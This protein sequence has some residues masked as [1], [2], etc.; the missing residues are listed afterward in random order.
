MTD[1]PLE[2]I[3]RKA[4]LPPRLLGGPAA[5]E[6]GRGEHEI[7]RP[8]ADALAALGRSGE[9][10]AYTGKGLESLAARLA[11]DHGV[12]HTHLCSSGTAAV[13]LALRGLGIGP[14][15]EVILSAYDFRGNFSNIC[16]TGATP[17]LVDIRPDNGQLDVQQVPSA[18]TPATKAILASHLHGGRA[19][20]EALRKISDEQS[21][22][23]VE[24][25][26]QAP[27]AIVDGR[28]AGSWGD[29]SV[30]SFGGSKLLS[31]GRGGAVL[32]SRDDI[33]Q[34]IR[35]YTQRGND[36]YPLSEIQAA[37]LLPQWERLGEWN[38]RR[39]S[40]AAKLC[41]W[42]KAL[43]VASLVPWIGECEGTAL[44]KLGFWHEPSRGAGGESLTRDQFAAAAQAEG[45]PLA[46]GFRALHASHAR[47][48]FRAVGELPHTTRADTT[49]LT[50]HHTA[51]EGNE[52]SLHELA[53]GL[54]KVHRHASEL[55]A[56]PS[57][58][59]LRLS[60]E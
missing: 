29:V 26:C 13:E 33:L 37:I 1:P 55:A 49:V 48:R 8:V 53:A 23:L 52:Q 38:R 43:G 3:E 18:I 51:M 50:L 36:A 9:W 4:S 24:D 47:R 44:Y 30:L 10:R 27:G 41:G 28:I 60:F 15:D 42:L 5:C 19:G 31:A 57:K 11:A 58:T 21:I 32:T 14:G 6:G 56:I 54:A 20:M 45:V 59:A 16:L 35:I 7:D 22:P 34:R 39:A 40:N 2:L 46:P 25:A 17:V 12:R